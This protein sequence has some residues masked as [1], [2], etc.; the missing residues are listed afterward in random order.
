MR[1]IALALT[2]DQHGRILFGKT[3][4]HQRMSASGLP[5][6]WEIP[7]GEKGP[8]EK[9]RAAARR[10]LKQETKIRVPTSKFKRSCTRTMGDK[11]F[12]IFVVYPNSH[13]LADMRPNHEY[14][15]LK[16]FAVDEIPWTEMRPGARNFLE[17]VLQDFSFKELLRKLPR[18]KKLGR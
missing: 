18:N 9:I 11:I 2:I 17:P 10:E 14:F 12:I 6:I 7:G 1:E 5:E 13:E 15:E 16:W 8:R 4:R 3:R